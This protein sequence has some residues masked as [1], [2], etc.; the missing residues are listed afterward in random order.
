MVSP[1]LEKA[2][3]K[4][5]I[6]FRENANNELLTDSI[7]LD[8]YKYYKQSINGNCNIP[9]PSYLNIKEYK[10][11][12]AWNSIIDMSQEESVEKYISLSFIF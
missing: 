11:W 10:K 9:K 3:K 12:T 1:E 5:I 4:A 2:F 6:K 7:K 8:A